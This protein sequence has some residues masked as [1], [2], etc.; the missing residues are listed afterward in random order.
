M[1]LRKPLLVLLLPLILSTIYPVI[2]MDNSW[3]ERGKYLEYSIYRITRYYNVNMSSNASS[4]LTNTTLWARMKVTIEDYNGTHIIFNFQIIDTNDTEGKAFTPGSTQTIAI[5]RNM[6]LER[7]LSIYLNP[8]LYPGENGVYYNETTGYSRY[9]RY[10]LRYGIIIDPLKGLMRGFVGRY[11][12]NISSGELGLHGYITM[13]SIMVYRLASTD[14]HGLEPLKDN[15]YQELCI[16]VFSDKPLTHTATPTQT[17]T[18]TTNGSG[19]EVD[20]P[21]LIGALIALVI[22]GI[23]TIKTIKH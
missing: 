19:K 9:G 2:S 3:I 14:I 10:R 22:V 17:T 21:L 8:S 16:N 12:L 1:Y 13:E 23:F 7:S 4:M 6:T 20:Y 5:D 18:P 15:E 11:L